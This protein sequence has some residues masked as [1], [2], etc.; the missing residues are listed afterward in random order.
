MNSE[1]KKKVNTALSAS[2]NV[3]SEKKKMTDRMM[4][5]A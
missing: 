4:S 2:T 5:I 1:Q 3:T